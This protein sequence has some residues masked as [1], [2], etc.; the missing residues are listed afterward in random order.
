MMTF[1]NSETASSKSVEETLNL[2]KT[3]RQFGLSNEE[4]IQRQKLYSFN[5]F[6]IKKDDPLW[7]KYLE[8]VFE[9]DSISYLSPPLK[10]IFRVLKFKEPMILLLLASALISIVMKQYDD[11]ISITC[12]I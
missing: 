6:E 5:E 7:F 3:D 8:K 2:L 1:L 10:L 9:S 12:V 11:A 4:V